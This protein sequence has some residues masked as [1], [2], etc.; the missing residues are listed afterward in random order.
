M[1]EAR[2]PSEDQQSYSAHSAARTG[3]PTTPPAVAGS[4][5]RGSVTVH[6]SWNGAT[7]VARWQVLAGSSA[8]A[9]APVGTAPRK[10]FETR[11]RFASSSRVVAVRA[12]DAGGHPLATSRAISPR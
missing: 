3:T 1:W 4:R 10:G 7:G 2:F 6:V 8:G 12:L 9:L 11:L 5:S